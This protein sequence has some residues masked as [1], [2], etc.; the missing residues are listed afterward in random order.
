MAS[1][2]ELLQATKAQVTEVT[3]EETEELRKQPN[4]VLL[5][6]REPSE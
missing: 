5:D 1:F 4:A 2:R 6:V 3:T